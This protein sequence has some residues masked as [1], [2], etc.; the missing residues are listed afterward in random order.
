M[1]RNEYGRMEM[2]PLPPVTPAKVCIIG[3]YPNYTELQRGQYFI[4]EG[5]HVLQ[6]TMRLAELPAEE[7]YY[8]VAIPYLLNKK[9]KEVPQVRALKERQ[10]LINEIKECGAEVVMPLGVFATQILLQEKGLTMNKVL[11]NVLSIPEL[12]GVTILPNYHPAALL[13]QPAGYKVFQQVISGVARI[14]HGIP[15][16][17]GETKYEVLRVEDFDALVEKLNSVERVAADLETSSLDRWKAIP[18][19]LG[20]CYEKNKAV[21]ITAEVMKQIDMNK[22]FATKCRWIWHNGKYDQEV[23]YWRGWSCRVDGDTILAHYCINETSGTH[24]LGQLAT[25]YL[26]ADEY[27]SKMNSEFNVIVNWEEYIKH[28]ADLIERVALDVDYTFQ[29]SHVLETKVLEHPDWSRLYTKILLPAS[30][31]LCRVQQNGAKVDAKYLESRIPMYEHEI[32][33]RE[34]AIVRAAQPYWNPKLYMVEMGAKTAPPVF[35]PTSPKQLAWLIYKQLGLKPDLARPQRSASTKLYSTCAENLEA[36]PDPP[37]FLKLLLELRSFKKQYKT[38]CLSYLEKKDHD[39]LVHA[40]FNL[41]ITATGRLSCVE[42]NLQNVPSSRPDLR[43]AFI[44][45]GKDRI[46][47]EVDYSGAELRVLAFMSGDPALT[48]AVTEGDLH[49]EVAEKIFGPDFTKL[50]RGMAKT[51]NFGIAYGRTGDSIDAVFG[52]EP[53]EGDKMIAMWAEMYPL[54]WKYLCSCADDVRSGRPLTTPYGRWRR[55]GL[56]SQKDLD[57]MSN[58]AKNFRIQSISSDNTL[59]A[60]MEAEPKL[61]EY[62]AYIINL[63]HDSILIDVPIA[64]VQA[65]SQLMSSTMVSVPKRHLNCDVKFH[66]DTDLGFTW[67]DFVAYDNKTHTVS[68]K[69]GQIPFEEY[70]KKECA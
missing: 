58:E 13:H 66:S 32:Q 4:S 50:Q 54:A 60:A 64:H 2:H 57:S 39:D 59:I 24:G 40:V 16:T 10:R 41:Y 6:E 21:V 62:D 3:E 35:K 29:L 38:Y 11:G 12:P 68:T 15:F 5:A 56:I 26:G 52:L 37:E 28:K 63:I 70:V 44:P 34:Q 30:A 33:L 53:G 51:I 49:S 7:C 65:V 47:M 55:F 25:L 31:F 1:I 45:R 42:P 67:G 23:C 18:W 14:A 69:A 27:K 36:I 61:K 48:K 46:L 43:R 19:V 20:L 22:L 9:T 17:P 8:T